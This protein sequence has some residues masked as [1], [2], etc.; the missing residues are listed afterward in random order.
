MLQIPPPIPLGRKLEPFT[1]GE[2]RR[3]L[4]GS[5]AAAVMGL[6]PWTTPVEL[7]MKKTGQ[8]TVPDEPDER[9][10]KIF[11]RGHMLEPF[12]VQMVVDKL[13]EMGLRV[14]VI[15][16]GERY[17]DG[18]FE[19]MRCEIDFELRVWGTVLIGDE[20]VTFDGE[21]INADAKSVTGFA[22]RKWGEENTEDVP[23]EYA[24]QFMFGLMVTGR[25]YCLVGALMSF[26]DVNIHWTV[27]DD[28]TIE[29][30]RPKMAEFW[31]DHVAA[32]VP[33][34]PIKFS[35]I[36]A[37]F[38]LDNGGEIE[39]TPEVVAQVEE[40]RRVKSNLRDLEEREETLT[41]AVGAFISPHAVL[42]YQGSV[43][44]TWKS[45]EDR[46]ISQPLIEEMTLFKQ[47]PKR[48]DPVTGDVL[49]TELV[50]M[51]DAVDQFK[52][53]AVI[54]V[55]RLPKPKQAKKGK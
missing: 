48:V 6:S 15:S 5:D 10:Q 7:W 50:P 2:R 55:L 54:R 32:G 25:R 40:L 52:R 35:D 43:I 28:E 8:T 41:F 29:A 47:V 14:E 30:M 4:G 1:D 45:Q 31:R 36:K 53:T 33:P 16:T 21:H 18:E 13:Q 37:L 44:A 22:R 38:P 19:F 27:R 3:F 12:I 23:I 46:R 51:P 9:R 17:Q 26:D 24:A 42:T 20:Y 49:E 39:A 11:R 34:D